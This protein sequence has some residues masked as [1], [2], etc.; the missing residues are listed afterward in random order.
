MQD[1]DY[2]NMKENKQDDSNMGMDDNRDEKGNNNIK[3]KQTQ[4]KQATKAGAAKKN[5]K[6][7]K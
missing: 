2:G 3:K 7:K 4:G 5:Q 6:T 1:E